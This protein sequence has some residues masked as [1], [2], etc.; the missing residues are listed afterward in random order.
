[1]RIDEALGGILGS[2]LIGV[3]IIGV[4]VAASTFIITLIIVF[5]TA[6][7]GIM[8]SVLGAILEEKKVI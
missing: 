7:V 3:P 6:L 1:L 4:L 5:H 8:G 2:M